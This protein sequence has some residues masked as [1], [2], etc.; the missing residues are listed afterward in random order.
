MIVASVVISKL[1]ERRLHEKG[2]RNLVRCDECAHTQQVVVA[3]CLRTGWPKH[4][5]AT[6]RLVHRDEQLEEGS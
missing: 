4:C 6:M 5:G 1:A 3:H 2:Y